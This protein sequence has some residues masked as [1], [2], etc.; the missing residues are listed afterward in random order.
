MSLAG[1]GHLVTGVALWYHAGSLEDDEAALLERAELA[2]VLAVPT[3]EE[4]LEDGVEAPPRLTLRTAYW[5]DEGAS[6]LDDDREV[7]DA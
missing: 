4:E 7:V 5:Y 1:E 3:D 2:E 6:L